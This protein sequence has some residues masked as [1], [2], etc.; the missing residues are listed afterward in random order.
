M[1]QETQNN[2]P[3][4]HVKSR[5]IRIAI[6]KNPT[7]DGNGFRFTA[8]APERRYEV[9][10]EWKS[11]TTFTQDEYLRIGFLTGKVYEKITELYEEQY[12]QKQA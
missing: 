7:S 2:K 12:A 4:A 8:S 11:A 1:T 10:G 5:D 3:V 9:E 6:W